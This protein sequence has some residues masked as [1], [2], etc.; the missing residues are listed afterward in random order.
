MI[1][2][3]HNLPDS[4]RTKFNVDTRAT[5]IQSKDFT[6]SILFNCFSTVQ[7][8]QISDNL[9]SK[10]FLISVRNENLELI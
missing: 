8:K 7:L 9:T 3:K 1:K 6:R 2:F 5:T 4:D 10:S